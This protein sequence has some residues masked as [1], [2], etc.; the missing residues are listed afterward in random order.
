MRV[1]IPGFEAKRYLKAS[2]ILP[3]CIFPDIC[4]FDELIITVGFDEDASI[5]K[6]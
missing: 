6:F 1:L 2:F 4:Y 5:V 3:V